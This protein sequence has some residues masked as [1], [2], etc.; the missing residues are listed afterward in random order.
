MAVHNGIH[1]EWVEREKRIWTCKV[2]DRPIYPDYDEDGNEDSWDWPIY[3]CSCNSTAE[4]V[5]TGE[6]EL[7]F[8][9][10]LSAMLKAYYLPAITESMTRPMLVDLVGGDTEKT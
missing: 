9:S 2:H 10:S 7:V 4:W 8:E 3:G 6:M 1:G 5:G